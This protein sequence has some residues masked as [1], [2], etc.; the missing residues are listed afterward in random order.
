MMNIKEG[1]SV[2]FTNFLIKSLL[3]VVLIRMQKLA[4]ELEKPII[5][6]NRK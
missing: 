1:L 4:E 6:K 2:W 5:R 3:A